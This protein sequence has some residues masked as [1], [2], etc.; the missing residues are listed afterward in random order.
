MRTLYVAAATLLFVGCQKQQLAP[1]PEPEAAELRMSTD[2]LWQGASAQVSGEARGMESVEVNGEGVAISGGTYATQVPLE[3]GVTLIE[4]V[5]IDTRGDT[6]FVRQGVLSGEF[7]APDQQIGDALTIRVNRTGLNKATELVGGL[8]DPVAISAGVTAINPVYEDSYGVLGWD[9][10]NIRADIVDVAFDTPVITPDPKPNL[11]E[12]EV[13]IPYIEIQANATGDV[14]GIDFDQDVWIGADAAVISANVLVGASNG[15]LVLDVVQPTVE[16]QGFWYDVSLIPGDIES[17]VLVDTL[18][19]T[20][21]GMLVTQL[22]EMLPG[23]L[24]G[25][26]AGLDISFDT[27]LL[28]TP[29]SISA[30]FAAATVD[31]AGIEL[32]TDVNVAVPQ[33]SDKPWAGFLAAPAVAMPAPSQADDIGMSVSDD[34]LNNVLFQVWR[35]GL[36]NMELDSAAGDIDPALLGQLGATGEARVILDANL[37]PVLIERGGATQV[38]LTELGVRIE[39][40]N[41][42]NGEYLDLSVTA[43]VGLELAIEEGVL[44]LELG[45]PNVIVDVRDSDWGASN[46]AITN[47]LA[48]QLP[49]DTLL[50]LL[51]DI[52][53]P[54]PSV[55]GISVNSGEA[56]RDQ[57]GVH[58]AVGINL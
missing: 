54:L 1:E 27:E 51:G 57:S 37:P 28:G 18:R 43:F 3:R 10:V 15:D 56:W 23:L 14:V 41:G 8:I 47:L 22:D 35:G 20:I 13:A 39:T 34:L 2:G 7:Q 16:L 17:F 25:A 11:L 52:E 49:I 42:E 5:G 38:Q 58:T 48:D 40:P 33:R 50:L 9:A 32:V 26:L 55:A 4:A 29:V 36:L 24:E 12:V 30:D 46:N 53:F 31:T 21:E 44:K 45:D 19:G 6:H